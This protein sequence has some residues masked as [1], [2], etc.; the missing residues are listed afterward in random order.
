MINDL[1]ILVLVVVL[2]ISNYILSI[3]LENSNKIIKQIFVINHMAK[4][5][6]ILIIFIALFASLDVV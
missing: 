3:T 5:S 4:L 1:I 6:I 2:I